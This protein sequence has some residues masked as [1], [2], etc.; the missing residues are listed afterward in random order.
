E[1]MYVKQHRRHHH[2]HHRRRHRSCTPECAP[3]PPIIIPIPM[4]EPAPPPP[5]LQITEYVQDIYPSAQYY[6][7]QVPV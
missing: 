5:P 2:H 1:P 6:N 7:D 4:Q 3:L